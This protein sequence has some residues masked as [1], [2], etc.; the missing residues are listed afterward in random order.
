MIA[1][2]LPTCAVAIVA[3]G[4]LSP[5]PAESAER[6]PPV[7]RIEG[8]IAT[9]GTVV[10]VSAIDREV[11]QK[12]VGREVTVR[13]IEG[14][15]LRG[16]AKYVIEAAP[17]TYDLHV[18]LEG[19][20]RLGDTPSDGRIIEGADLRS[21]ERPEEPKP[22]KKR[23]RDRIAEVVEKMRTWSDEKHVLAIEGAAGRAKALVKLVKTKPTSYD[24]EYGEP[25]AVVRWEIWSFR[26]Y[27]GS[28]RREP[29]AKVLRRF[30]FPKRSL[31]E[32]RWEFDPALGGVDV[33]AGETARRD[34]DF[35]PKPK[36]DTP[37]ESSR[38]PPEPPP[39]FAR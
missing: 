35:K 27:T 37:T 2:D 36:A 34:L 14:R 9:A 15:V 33:R 1:R 8:K 39:G 24:G 16:E 30:L 21:H 3:A 32:L 20:P 10:K 12:A 4:T 17:G 5:Q 19:R 25:I 18:E 22:L 23:D 29:R 13:E 11:R 31:G 6:A 7:G 38:P 26:K 28:W